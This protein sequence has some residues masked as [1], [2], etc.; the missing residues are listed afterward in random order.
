[1]AP[2]WCYPA[3]FAHRQSLAV[4]GKVGHMDRRIPRRRR[5]SDVCPDRALA[6]P[7]RDST[8]AAGSPDMDNKQMVGSLPAVAAAKGIARPRC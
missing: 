3:A 1:M 7:D 4:R 5:G 2:I 8:Q 6:W